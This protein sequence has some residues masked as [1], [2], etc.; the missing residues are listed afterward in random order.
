MESILDLTFF[1]F[2]AS[3]RVTLLVLEHGVALLIF[4]VPQPVRP[5]VIFHHIELLAGLSHPGSR[6]A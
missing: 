3:V 4:P 1:S 5:S 2:Q 6:L